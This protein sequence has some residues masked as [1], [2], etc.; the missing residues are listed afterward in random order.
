VAALRAGG[1]VLPSEDYLDNGM[2][3]LAVIRR[4]VMA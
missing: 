4:G 3:T 1:I 2:A